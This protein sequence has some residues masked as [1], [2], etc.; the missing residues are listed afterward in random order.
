[1]EE[2]APEI[3]Q[4][5]QTYQHASVIDVE[6]IEIFSQGSSFG[7]LPAT[8]KQVAG[9]LP[10]GLSIKDAAR[11][12][13]V[14]VNTVRARIKSG[15]LAAEKVKGP[16]NEQW[17][18]FIGNLP[19]SSHQVDSN[20]PTHSQTSINP[21]IERLLDIIEKQSAKLEAASGQIGYLQAQLQASQEHVKLL[22][23][24]QRIPFWRR[25]WSWLAGR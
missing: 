23:D 5:N 20:L 10:A 4:H 25:A 3:K 15:E 14:S 16:T 12:L 11:V 18:V 8:S 1:M 9:N 22:E 21:E 2:P 6:G 19:A 17:R 7:N 24:S 13:G